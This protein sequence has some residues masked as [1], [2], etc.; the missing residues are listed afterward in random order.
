MLYPAFYGSVVGKTVSMGGTQTVSAAATFGST[1]P[2]YYG[3]D[4]QWI[5]LNPM[6]Y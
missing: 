2:S 3:F 4:N 1:G 5:E 6:T